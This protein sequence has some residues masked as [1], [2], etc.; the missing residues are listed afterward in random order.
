V[1]GSGPK[2][3]WGE[4]QLQGVTN[5]LRES[6]HILEHTGIHTQPDK[7]AVLRFKGVLWPGITC[8][9]YYLTSMEVKRNPP[10]V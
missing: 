10:I 6:L 8:S 1:G 9:F 2:K 7:Y 5:Q 4:K 3:I